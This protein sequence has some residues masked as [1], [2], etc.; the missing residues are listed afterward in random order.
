V[1]FREF[2]LTVWN[3]CTLSPTTLGMFSF[4]LYDEQKTGVL[5]LDDLDT[6]LREIFSGQRKLDALVKR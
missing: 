3:Y 5:S 4:D 6:M 1:D 2:V